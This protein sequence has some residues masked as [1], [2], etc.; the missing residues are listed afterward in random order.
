MVSWTGIPSGQ[1][2]AH[3]ARLGLDRADG[4]ELVDGPGGA[5]LGHDVAGGGGVD[6]D[7]VPVGPALERLP[8]LPADLADGEDLLHPGSGG[9][10]EVEHLGQRP[11]PPGD[12]HLQVEPQVLLQ[13]G[14]GVHG[15]GPQGR[16]DHL[17]PE[18]HRAALEEGGDVAPPVGRHE[19]HLPPL[20]GGEEGHGGRDGAL[21][22]PALPGEEEEPAPEEIRRRRD[23]D[24][25]NS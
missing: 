18:A 7:E 5:E 6:H 3:P 12:R 8:H 17:G 23:G 2:L 19:Q 21:A 14:L 1:Q 25:A 10:H 16:E 22:D 9:G 4:H 11:D 15:H 24:R 20:L 13:G